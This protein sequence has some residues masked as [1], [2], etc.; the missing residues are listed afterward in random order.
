MRMI[1]GIADRTARG[2]F[3]GAADVFVSASLM[4]TYG[5]TLIEAMSCGVPVVAFRTGGIPEAVSEEGGILCALLDADA[6]R[7]AIQKLRNCEELR[8]ELGNAASKL[9]A[10]RNAKSRFGAAFARVYEA[11]LYPGKHVSLSNQP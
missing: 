6:F 3:Y 10:T 2:I 11:C 4:E 9:V 8:N 1:G 5:F 7:A